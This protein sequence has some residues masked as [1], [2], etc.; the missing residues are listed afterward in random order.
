MNEVNLIDK[1]LKKYKVI[2]TDYDKHRVNS[3]E[4]NMFKLIDQIY[5]I[6]ETKHS[7]FLAFLLD[8]AANHGQGKLFLTEFLKLLNIEIKQNSVWKVTCEKDNIDI[9]LKCSHPEKS[10]IIIENKSNWARDQKNQ[11]YRY[12]FNEIYDENKECSYNHNSDVLGVNDRIIYLAPN[13]YKIY[14]VNSLK[15]PE[16]NSCKLTALF[17]ENITHFY[18]YSHINEWLNRCLEIKEFPTRVK[19]FIM[20]YL[21][22]WQETNFKNRFYMEEIAKYFSTSDNEKDAENKKEEEWAA[23]VQASEYIG[24]I[25][26]QWCRKNE[27]QL[28]SICDNGWHFYKE[29]IGDLRIYSS[30]NSCKN[31]YTCFVYEYS[32]GLSIWKDGLELNQKSDYKKEFE[33]VFNQITEREFTFIDLEFHQN[34]SYLMQYCNNE[35]TLVFTDE[36]NY[37]WN[38]GNTNLADRL[39][40]IL[41]KYLTDDVKKLFDKIDNELQ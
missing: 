10:T 28:K 36:H 22:F 13:P 27:D 32:K 33:L 6:G 5:G 12:W 21:E 29:N 41:Q 24:Q 38:A 31:N 9:L 39:T 11:L 18:F 34:P 8:P 26:S 1:L 2:S 15:K 40:D 7:K 16:N 23:F 14:Q 17:P 37:G 30:E 35:Y 4:F 25:N 19:Y 3:K 20:D